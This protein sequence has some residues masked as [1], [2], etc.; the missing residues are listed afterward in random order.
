MRPAE[1]AVGEEGPAARG[2]LGLRS[3]R[4]TWD[5]A[6]GAKE[7]QKERKRGTPGDG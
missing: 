5:M 6:L 7:A 3:E 2:L 4:R 1:E